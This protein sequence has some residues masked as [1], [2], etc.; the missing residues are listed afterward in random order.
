MAE[1]K[2]WAL[3]GCLGCLGIV[4]LVVLFGAITTGVAYVQ[5]GKEQV[6]QHLSTQ[7]VPTFV[8]T[9]TAGRVF[10]DFTRTE[11]NVFPLRPGEEM[12]VEATYDK[13]SFELTES[14]EQVEGEGWT[15]RVRFAS[16][17]SNM[18]ALL[19]R[20]L[21][22]T[23]PKVRVY[24]PTDVPIHLD[25]KLSE[26]GGT[27]DLAGM[28]LT[29]LDVQMDKSGFD[30]SVDEPLRHPAERISLQGAMGG[31]NISRLGNASPRRLDVGLEMGG[32]SLD[33]RGQWLTDSDISISTSMGGTAVQLPRDVTIIGLDSGGLRIPKET[34]IPLPTLRFTTSVSNGE[35]EVIP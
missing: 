35:I 20:L 6:E 32:L 9:E 1:K 18:M 3:Y 34:E 8:A 30:L 16:S 23:S 25:L 14:L 19:K 5:V 33:L 12:R 11:F 21:G 13:N 15:Y 31:M 24:L 4:V 26:G 2:K 22:G 27:L 7:E 29:E 10:L 17:G 28:W